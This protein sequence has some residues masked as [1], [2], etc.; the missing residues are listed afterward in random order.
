[1]ELR[2]K[3]G[4]ARTAAVTFPDIS[5]HVAEIE[6]RIDNFYWTTRILLQQD[7][8]LN[9]END[10]WGRCYMEVIEEANK[11]AATV[12]K[13]ERAIDTEARRLA[14][15]APLFDV[16]KERWLYSG[17]LSRSR[18]IYTI[19]RGVIVLTGID[20]RGI[21]ITNAAE[22]VIQDLVDDGV[23]DPTKPRLILYS[24]EK[25]RWDGLAVCEGKFAGFVMLRAWSEE[26]A[27]QAVIQSDWNARSP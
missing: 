17:S 11:T 23:L 6:A 26:D 24:D 21:S 13:V 5:P 10:R 27:V 15:M 25:G 2:D 8:D 19:K 18:F 20:R 4:R 3:L 16:E 12:A 22:Q 7:H 14:E 1:M 9:A